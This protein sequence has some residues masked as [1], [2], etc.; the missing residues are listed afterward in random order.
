MEMLKV[1]MKCTF[2]LRVFMKKTKTKKNSNSH[3]SGSSA[4]CWMLR[5][6]WKTE[7]C[8]ALKRR[9]QKMWRGDYRYVELLNHLLLSLLV[10]STKY[11]P[12]KQPI[13]HVESTARR[14]RGSRS[15]KSFI[16]VTDSRDERCAQEPQMYSYYKSD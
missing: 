13:L 16:K 12:L 8:S 15:V 3:R 4:P 11:K 10:L 1:R 7:I 9:Q 2:L 6:F 14:Q 5:Y